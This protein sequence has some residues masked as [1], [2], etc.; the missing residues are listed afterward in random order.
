MEARVCLSA[1][2][3]PLS[4][5][6]RMRAALAAA[7]LPPVAR[8]FCSPL[9]RARETAEALHGA[10]EAAEGLRELGMGE[11][12][13]LA[14]DEIRRRWP[15][16][17]ARRGEAPFTCVPPGGEPPADCLARSHAALARL[18]AETEGDVAVVAHAGVNR[19]LL[20]GLLGKP[21][22]EFLT[23]PQPYGCVNAL[24]FDGTALTVERVAEQPRPP[25]T[26]ALC[27]RL[28]AAAETPEP[29]RA[30]TRAVAALAE[31]IGEALAAKG[32]ALDLPLLRAAALLHDVARTEPMH[33]ETGG[34]WLRALGYP[35]A[36]ALVAAHHELPAEQERPCEGAA[37]YL[38]DKLIRGTERVT[39]DER[40]AASAA[41]CVT[42]EARENHERRRRQAERVERMLAEA[43]G[44]F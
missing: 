26:D 6:G 1:L 5:P 39:L 38:A 21:L 34:E 24:R 15:E 23:I 43:A 16:I 40:F 7:S 14:F 25:L 9:R 10:P 41:K 29:V 22:D 44:A 28:L 3:P 36:G 30:H 11:W 8:V 19:L 20:C 37:L 4:R 27:E 42:Q 35:E 2:D 18:L 13:G 17:Y 31:R 33:A 32:Y 12:D